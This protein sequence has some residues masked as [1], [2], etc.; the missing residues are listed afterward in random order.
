MLFRSDRKSTRLISVLEPYLGGMSYIACTDSQNS[1]V[2]RV[3][4]QTAPG[5]DP[6]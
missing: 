1:R 6:A 4:F 2:E 5:S 3:A